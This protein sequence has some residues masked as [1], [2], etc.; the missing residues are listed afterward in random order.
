M[1]KI[2]NANKSLEQQLIRVMTDIVR[3]WTQPSD[4]G[5]FIDTVS[6]IHV[7]HEVIPNAIQQTVGK[8]NVSKTEEE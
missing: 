4:K 8:Y 6:F 5:R 7:V 3:V 1:K 2:I